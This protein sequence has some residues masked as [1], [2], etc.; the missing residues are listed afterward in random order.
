MVV[1]YGDLIVRETSEEVAVGH[2]G[3]REALLRVEI[4]K[5]VQLMGTLDRRYSGRLGLVRHIVAG[6]EAWTA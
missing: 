4:L 6:E 1:I 2:L 5:T 3:P